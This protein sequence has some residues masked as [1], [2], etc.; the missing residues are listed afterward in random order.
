MLKPTKVSF[1]CQSDW[2]YVNTFV[3][4]T[5]YFMDQISAINLLDTRF[6]YTIF[7]LSFS[8]QYKM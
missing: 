1:S 5:T 2:L 4:V 7:K 3:G 8:K 6:I